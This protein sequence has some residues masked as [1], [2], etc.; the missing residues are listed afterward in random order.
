[1]KLLLDANLSPKLVDRLRDAGYEVRNVTDLDTL[2]A[3]DEAIFARAAQDGWTVVTADADFSML[4][5]LRDTARP[6]V[7]LLR[8][9]AELTWTAHTDL[10][11]AN[12]DAV[13]ADLHR[14]AVVSLSQTRLAVR[15]LP[16][17]PAGADG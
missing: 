16:M 8:H 9:V 1:M 15:T 6:S 14:G 13:A 7:L 4:V 5:A 10:L 12:L 11:V 2:T 17:R 3:S